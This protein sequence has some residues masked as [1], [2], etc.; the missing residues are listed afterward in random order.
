MK[1]T[2][3]IG[4]SEASGSTAGLTF[5]RN[6]YGAYVR[7]RAIPVQPGSTRQLDARAA[8]T[9][10]TRAWS[11]ILTPVQRAGWTLYGEAVTLTD[12]LGQS[13]K[14]PGNSWYIK[15]NA[16]RY[17]TRGS[18][19]IVQDAPASTVQIVPLTVG[20]TTAAVQID[21]SLAVSSSIVDQAALAAPGDS[22]VWGH[23]SRPLGV[24]ENFYKAPWYPC[25]WTVEAALANQPTL[26]IG[27]T[28][29]LY[30]HLAGQR[31]AIEF[32]VSQKDGR[33]SNFTRKYVT[34]TAA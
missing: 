10:L 4:I 12:S 17:Y 29:K 24:G 15:L 8:L 31:L 33:Q 27:S 19:L 14:L 1:F 30:P 25:G 26:Y 16:V 28:S 34:T 5:S 23:V 13:Y 20:T 21:G 11:T 3:G 22:F 7:A 18:A 2:A 32:A 9:Y 6:R